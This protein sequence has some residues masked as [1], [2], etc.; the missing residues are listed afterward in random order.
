MDYE[1]NP[2][3]PIYIQIMDIIK[4]KVLSEE[5][6]EGDRVP[7]VRDLSIEFSVN[8][9][10]MQ[11]ALSELEREGLVYSERT[12]GRFITTDKGK[13]N[14]TREAMARHTIESF[15]K[16]MQKVGFTTEQIITKIKEV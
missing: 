6:K 16:Q 14:E 9:N 12:A 1:Y 8:P 15:L 7:S 11:R 10:T 5:W 2:N 4:L 13:I 3:I